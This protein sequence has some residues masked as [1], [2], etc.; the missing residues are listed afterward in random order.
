MI[1][2]AYCVKKPLEQSKFAYEL[3]HMKADLMLGDNC[4]I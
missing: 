4:E 1:M 3:L 2:I